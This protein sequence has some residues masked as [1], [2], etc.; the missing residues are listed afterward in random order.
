MKS[1]LSR[2]NILTFC[3]L[4]L[5]S[6]STVFAGGVAD[7]CYDNTV[8]ITDGSGHGSGVLFTR[9]NITFVW[10]V[11]HVADIFMRDDGSFK[12]VIIL[13]DDK[14]A[15]ARVIRSSDC[16]TDQDIAL[17][18]I[19]ENCGFV[20]DAS[21][22][23]DFNNVQLGQNIIHCGNPF[24]VR[25]NGNLIFHGNIS[26]VGRLFSLRFMPVP[27]EMDQ[28][29]IIAYPG[30]SGGGVFDAETGDILGFMSLSGEPGLTVIVPTREV[31]KWAKKHDCLWA[32]D[33]EV[34]LPKRIIPWRSDKLT[35]LLD[36]RDTSKI[37]ARWGVEK[38]PVQS[39]K[40]TIEIR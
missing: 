11:S 12:E 20:G 28:C 34:P 36:K 2:I 39:K 1:R 26:H 4:L 33:R 6:V 29:D 8:V 30:C 5:F 25:L 7:H 19:T 32:F 24:N 40:F 9:G 15:K 18:L 16:H 35:R 10:T 31:Y 21:F 23:R 14:K 37:D 17:L 3:L 27:R 38:K 22:Y 13:R